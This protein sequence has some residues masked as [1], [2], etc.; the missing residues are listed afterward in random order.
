MS[1]SRLSSISVFAPCWNEA[2]NIP[3][4]VEQA[5]NVLPTIAKQFEVI[6]VNDGSSDTTRELVSHLQEIYPFLRIVSHETNQGY[7]ASLR[8]GIR[9]ARF[10]WIFWTDGDLQF[11][12]DSLKA[13]ISHTGDHTAVIGY[14]KHRA[15]TFIRKLNGE[16]YTQLINMLFR[17]GV[18]DIDCAFKLIPRAPLQQ[19]DIT[20]SGAFTS[21]EILIRLH[22]ANIHFV[23]LPVTHY[24]R[25][26][27]TPTGGSI[28]VIFKGLRETIHF[29]IAST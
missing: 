25:K 5:A 11:H 2:E 16:L 14:R 6:I 21:A 28:K 17:I 7:G 27:G 22:R 12:L 13:F 23:Q 9:S 1:T 4:F 8:T 19:L 29:F 24:K 18:R 26:F 10:D 20:S 15:D 3:A